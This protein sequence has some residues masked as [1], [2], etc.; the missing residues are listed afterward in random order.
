MSVKGGFSVY[1]NLPVDGGSVDGDVY[2]IDLVVGFCFCCD[3]YVW[4]DCV[5]VI[6]YVVDVCVAGVINYHYVIYIS[7]VSDNFVFV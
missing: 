7:E 6:L 1:G 3:I 5:E 2:E 4:V